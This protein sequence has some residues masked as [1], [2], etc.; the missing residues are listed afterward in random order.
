MK[1]CL[2]CEKPK[3]DKGKYCKRCGYKHRIRPRGLIYKIVVKN[4]SWFKKDHI[5]SSKG[6][7]LKSLNQYSRG[8]DAIHEWVERHIKEP[9]EC[10]ICKS[11]Q[12]LEWANKSGK[13]KHAFRD[14]LR[15][16]KK[17]HHRYDYEH[18]GARKCFYT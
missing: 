12:K 17:C 18:F 11:T 16:C 2:D 10:Q 15:L 6:K 5:P 9:K 4:K 1:F 7:M 14:W 8:Y 13:Y 3:S